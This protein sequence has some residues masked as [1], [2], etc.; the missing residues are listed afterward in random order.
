MKIA[1]D[2]SPLQKS[3]FL[4]HRV[5]GTGFYIENLKSALLQ[6]FPNNRY[7]F[8]IRGE[9]IPKDAD[10]VHYPYFEP[11]FLTLPLLKKHKTIV[12]VHDLT[13]LV[14][15]K[16]FPVGI[17]G[18]I[19]WQI[20]K[21]I[22]KN[23]DAIITDSICSKNDIIKYTGINSSKIHFIYLAASW[24]FKKMEKSSILGSIREKYK[25]P[26]KFV[27]YV[28][29][30]TWNKNLPR[31]LEA[32]KK[33]NV[34]LVMV[35]SALV[36]EGFDRLNP[37]NQDLLKVQKLAEADKR[38]IR[39]GFVPQKDLVV[40]YNAATVFAMPSLYEG[41]GL[42]VLEA[43]SCGCPVVTTKE[44]SIPEVGGD[45]V[46]YVNA[47]DIND[48]ANGIS[49][50]CF[51]QKLQKELLQKGIMQAKKFSWEKTAEK[52]IKVYES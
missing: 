13:P 24:E 26:E 44:G 16:Y 14:F 28:G 11:F 37:W 39:L 34:T 7:T 51:N 32:I 17:R 12:T 5:R 35:G 49:E 45:A 3:N 33:I 46:Y 43:M 25:L 27:L 18:N 6:Y 1:L 42:P 36:Q 19:K 10:L 22:L 47:Y 52:T 21:R 2:T 8:F 40:L 20:Q 41:F 30:V 29:D 50:V 4:Q 15:H 38:I 23:T 31:L 9:K 48:I